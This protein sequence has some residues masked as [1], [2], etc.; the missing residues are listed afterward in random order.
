MG[1]GQGSQ[2]ASQSA[3]AAV[4]SGSPTLWFVETESNLWGLG[5]AYVLV[6]G[7]GGGTLDLEGRRTPGSQ[8]GSF[9]LTH[10]GHPFF[11]SFYGY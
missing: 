5:A 11:S 2:V 7:Q 4:V 3:K 8:A 9:T 10:R 1:R 6:L